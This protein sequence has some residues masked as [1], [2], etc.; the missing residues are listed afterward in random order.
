MALAFSLAALFVHEAGGLNTE[1]TVIYR[2]FLN[3]VYRIRG[4]RHRW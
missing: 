3:A 2:Y 1:Q 4:D